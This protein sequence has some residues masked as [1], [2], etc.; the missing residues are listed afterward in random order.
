MSY[1]TELHCHTAEFSGCSN[2]PGAEM[3]EKY[4][5]HGYTTVVVTNHFRESE[6]HRDLCDRFFAAAD[7]ARDAAGDRL[8]VITAMEVTLNHMPNDF[9]VY[10]IG[11]EDAVNMPDMFGL[12]V[13]DLKDRVNSLGGLLIQ[14]HPFRDWQR[15]VNPGDVN[16]VEVYNG[17]SGHRSRNDVAYHWGMRYMERYDRG[18]I[19]TSGTD[20]HDRHHMPT[21]GIITENEITTSAELVETLRSGDFK[22]IVTSLGDSDY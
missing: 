17:H 20:H 12:S 4:I 6:D 18:Y 5:S 10:G 11:H 7:L 22:R 1:K 13:R 16:G 8:H 19:L 14:A 21:G 3:V 9:L 2:V 15:V